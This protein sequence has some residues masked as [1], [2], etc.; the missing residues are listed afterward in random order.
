MAPTT[1]TDWTRHGM[2]DEEAREYAKQMREN[3]QTGEASKYKWTR[4]GEEFAASWQ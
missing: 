1:E 4:G 3:M 2:T